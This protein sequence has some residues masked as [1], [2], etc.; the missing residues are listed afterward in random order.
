M[1]CNPPQLRGILHH[2]FN[3][4]ATAIRVVLSIGASPALRVTRAPKAGARLM[5]RA[6]D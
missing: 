3:E 2:Q 5:K 4:S 1:K 6:S